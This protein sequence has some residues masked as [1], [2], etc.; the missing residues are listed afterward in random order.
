MVKLGGAG[1]G[2]AVGKAGALYVVGVRDDEIEEI[3]R[4][5]E[6][7][8]RLARAIIRKWGL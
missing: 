8:E 3:P 6:I 1:T 5:K 4:H 2:I 7:N